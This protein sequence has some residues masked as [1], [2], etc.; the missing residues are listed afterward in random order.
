MLVWHFPPELL[1]GRGWLS[2]DGCYQWSIARGLYCVSLPC[3]A[4][5][6]SSSSHVLTYL[7]THK[8][9]CASASLQTFNT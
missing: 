6:P 1:K 8:H 4:V 7:L 2:G 9:S 5:L 3:Y